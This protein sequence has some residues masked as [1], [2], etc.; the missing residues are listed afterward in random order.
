MGPLHSP[1]SLFRGWAWIFLHQ[2]LCNVSNQ[3]RS[4]NEDII[5]RPWRPLPSGRI[6]E[7]HAVILRWALV[8][9][10]L[11]FSAVFGPDLVLVTIGL[12]VTTFLYDEG[13]LA[14]HVIGKNLCNVGG[15]VT[16]EIGATKLIGDF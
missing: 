10:C 11:G 3:A 7:P 15:Y 4:K 9:V 14:S 5:N 2:L 12:F 16:F 8:S 13:G 6:T 1:Q